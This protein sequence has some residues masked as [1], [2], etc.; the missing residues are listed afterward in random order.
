MKI[1]P[2]H[3]QHMLLSIKAKVNLAALHE[4]ILKDKRYKDFGKRFRWDAFT[5]AG[6]T[7]WACTNLYP[8]A[9]DDHIDTAL[10]RIIKDLS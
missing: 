5:L 6:L 7:G 2:E 10:K 9:N 8:Y 1:K 4:Q 3:Y